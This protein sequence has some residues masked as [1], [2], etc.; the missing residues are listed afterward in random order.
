M[1]AVA[2]LILHPGPA[3]DA[4]G[5]ETWVGAARAAN[6]EGHRAGFV[7]VGA[8]SVTVT[9]GPPDGR[10]FGARL[11]TFLEHHRPGG[12]VVLGSGAV[13]LATTADRRAFVEAAR[14]PEPRALTNNRF[15]ADIVAIPTPDR[16]A[17][18]ERGLRELASD[19]A[20]PRWLA[21]VAGYDVADRRSGWRLGFD[22]DG[23]LDLAL[24]GSGA[25]P[26]P[27]PDGLLDRVVD[28]LDAVGAV[29]LDPGAELVVAGRTAAGSLGWLERATA[30]RT[31][32][33]VE[34]RGLR[35]RVAGQRPA[36]SALGLLLDRDGPDALGAILGELGD[37]AL[38]DTRVLLAHRFGADEGGWPVA[39]DRFASDLLAPDRIHDPWLRALTAAAVEAP[40]PIVLGGHS[41]V[42]PGLRLA[43]GRRRQWT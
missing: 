16:L 35:T 3:H 25:W 40:I 19:N 9:G 43:L 30:A 28:R 12:V 37:A 31:R 21:D 6:A 10:T 23:P 36:R 18:M 26:V 11:A 1:T 22:I 20:L 24:L 33:L 34:E 27:P 42:G 2:V 38:V 17:R 13:P 39:E 8:D 29:A 5:I 15:S 41:L 4:G 14:G 32:A 7:A